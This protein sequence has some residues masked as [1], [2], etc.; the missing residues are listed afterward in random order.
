M[1]A[2]APELALNIPAGQSVAAA[3]PGLS[4]KEPAGAGLQ[5]MAPEV[6]LKVPAGQR[7]AAVAP[8]ISM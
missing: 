2:M 1:Q 7:I 3:A 8:L 6:A 4:T 5:A